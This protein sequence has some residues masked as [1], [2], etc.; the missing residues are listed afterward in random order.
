MVPPVLGRA[1]LLTPDAAHR[2]K[3]LRSSAIDFKLARE[4]AANIGQAFEAGSPSD[5]CAIGFRRDEIIGIRWGFN[6]DRWK[7]EFVMFG[8]K[9]QERLLVGGE[10]LLKVES[11]GVPHHVGRLG[12]LI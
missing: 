2:F 5:G 12:A 4:S 11:C 6:D 10:K 7:S 3:P 8:S 9:I 1:D